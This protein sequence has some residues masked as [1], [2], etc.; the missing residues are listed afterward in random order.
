MC[1]AQSSMMENPPLH[2]FLQSMF[3]WMA[4]RISILDFLFVEIKDK[5]DPMNIM[6]V[7]NCCEAGLVPTCKLVTTI[8]DPCKRSLCGIT[9]LIAVG[10]C[11]EGH[12]V[13]IFDEGMMMTFP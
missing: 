13:C 6:L 11:E 5:C 1:E 4:S 3:H 7:D 8:S 10:C 12:E 9:L 2:N